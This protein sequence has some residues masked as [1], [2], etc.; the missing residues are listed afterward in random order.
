MFEN[1]KSRKSPI[2]IEFIKRGLLT[3]GQVDRV[4][5]YQRD[6]KELKFAEIVDILD[7]CDKSALLDVLSYKIQVTGVM[8]DGN[9]EINPVKYLP[10]D[11]IINYKVIPFSLVG[12]KLKVAF[13]DP[14]NPTKVKEISTIRTVETNHVDKEE[15]ATTKLVDNIIMTAIERRASDIH[16]EPMEDKIR[17]RY[18]I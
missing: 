5:E 9:L 13:S 14:Q 6:H 8:L 18:R 16:I 17:V 11:M 15:K 3:E 12:N 1:I 4:L 10:R 2:G 7:M